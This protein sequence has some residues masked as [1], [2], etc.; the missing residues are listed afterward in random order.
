MCV[1]VCCRLR[2]AV[3]VV[4]PCVH[5]SRSTGMTVCC[6]VGVAVWVLQCVC[7]SVLQSVCGSACG[8]SVCARLVFDRPCAHASCSTGM[9]VRCS[10]SVAVCVLQCV[11]LAR[12]GSASSTLPLVL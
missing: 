4:S 12:G 1:A 7:R 9:T 3:R 5:A 8:V 11:C 2:V 6:S 10:M